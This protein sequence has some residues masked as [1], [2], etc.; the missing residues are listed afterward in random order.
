MSRN[1]FACVY[2][3]CNNQPP[4]VGF[5]PTCE[6]SKSGVNERA[7]LWNSDKLYLC[8]PQSD[9]GKRW[10]RRKWAGRNTSTSVCDG[11]SCSV[12]ALCALSHKTRLHQVALLRQALA[13]HLRHPPTQAHRI[14]S[15]WCNHKI[16]TIT[17]SQRYFICI[18]HSNGV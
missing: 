18:D 7:E 8:K 6:E 17:N 9:C 4:D 11:S 13:V 15:S 2:F 16:L 1:V 14:V 12:C 5:T 3:W 10:G